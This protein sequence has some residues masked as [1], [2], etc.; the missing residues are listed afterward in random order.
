[1][2]PYRGGEVNPQLPE[3]CHDAR[4]AVTQL[5]RPI[6][7]AFRAVDKSERMELTAKDFEILF[8]SK[9]ERVSLAMVGITDKEVEMFAP[10]LDP[11]RAQ[12]ADGHANP[13]AGAKYCRSLFLNNNKI[14]ERGVELLVDAL[15]ANTTL[16]ELYLQYNK[17]GDAGC[18]HINR[19]LISNRRLRKLDLGANGIGESGI[20]LV[21]D[22]LQDNGTIE[23][24]GLFGNA[25]ETRDDL[26]EV[27][28][29]LVREARMQRKIGIQVKNRFRT[30]I[31]EELSKS[32]KRADELPR[33]WEE[34]LWEQISD[35]LSAFFSNTDGLPNNSPP[36]PSA[37]L[38]LAIPRLDP[39][40]QVQIRPQPGQ[41]PVALRAP[42]DAPIVFE[43][44][45]G[46]LARTEGAKAEM[47]LAYTDPA[48]GKPARGWLSD[49][50]SKN[51]LCGGMVSLVTY[52]NPMLMFPSKPRFRGD[53][54]TD[55]AGAQYVCCSGPLDPN[56]SALLG[57]CPYRPRYAARGTFK[58][59]EY[60]YELERDRETGRFFLQGHGQC[61][62]IE[63]QG[64]GGGEG[65]PR[66]VVRS[67]KVDRIFA[68][69][70]GPN[71][72]RWMDDV[73]DSKGEVLEFGL[74][75]RPDQA[76]V[77]VNGGVNAMHV[78]AQPPHPHYV[79]WRVAHVKYNVEAIA[80]AWA[81]L[82]LQSEF[83]KMVSSDQPFSPFNVVD[84]KK[85]AEL[86]VGV[87]L[88]GETGD[89]RGSGNVR[90]MCDKCYE[91]LIDNLPPSTVDPSLIR[92]K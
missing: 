84:A 82:F 71:P 90:F 89:T 55:E 64:K 46:D 17:L 31:L 19:L 35:E 23:S 54:F 56:A 72:A 92:K 33:S 67:P 36:V 8:G 25:P 87:R 78:R 34:V 13:H 83:G 63:E 48:T 79:P 22:G 53:K 21:V 81:T 42:K 73:G 49:E 20:G 32:G 6:V 12:G 74:S 75:L 18:K 11:A 60:Y 5:P 65:I 91:S 9:S 86:L 57:A 68:L 37:K 16:T 47:E 76:A 70:P 45:K 1:M 40:E 69:E 62:R 38:L 50:A 2:A 51:A 85:V 52:L 4:Y 10:L 39:G 41:P 59:R 15:A 26:A 24:I 77:L 66:H 28:R 80:D 14:G 44:V 88:A 27:T 43:V 3:G 58:A 30:R 7:D 61:I 29:R